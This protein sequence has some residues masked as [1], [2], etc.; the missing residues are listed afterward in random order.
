VERLK[1]NAGAA[2]VRER[3]VVGLSPPPY[4]GG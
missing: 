2:T 4:A 1:L 3:V